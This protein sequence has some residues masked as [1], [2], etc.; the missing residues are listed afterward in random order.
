MGCADC[1]LSAL[2]RAGEIEDPHAAKRRKANAAWLDSLT[3]R[4]TWQ[5]PEKRFTPDAEPEDVDPM[6][7]FR[8]AY[9]RDPRRDQ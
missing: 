2:V 5:K 1:I 3:P 4:E 9:R 8:G 6:E 7:E